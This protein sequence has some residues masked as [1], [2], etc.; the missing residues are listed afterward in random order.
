M[1]EKIQ[2]DIFEDS[3]L[4]RLTGEKEGMISLMFVIT[5]SFFQSTNIDCSPA[6]CQALY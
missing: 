3:S 2:I 5:G 4:G 6:K 1:G